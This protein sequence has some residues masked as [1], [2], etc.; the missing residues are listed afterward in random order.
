M[1][2]KTETFESNQSETLKTENFQVIKKKHSY[3]DVIN[4]YRSQQGNP[5]EVYKTIEAFITGEENFLILGD[6]NL[7]FNE[8]NSNILI[9]SL[10][11]S[12]FHQLIKTPTQ[13][14]GRIIDHAYFRGN[15]QK[16]SIESITYSPYYS[17]HDALLIVVKDNNMDTD[18][19]NFLEQLKRKEKEKQR[20]ENKKKRKLMEER[21]QMPN[22]KKLAEEMKE[23]DNKLTVQDWKYQN[24]K[25]M[26]FEL[27][28]DGLIECHNC[29][30]VIDHIWRH[31]AGV[32]S[33]TCR[34]DFIPFRDQWRIFMEKQK[35]SENQEDM[36]K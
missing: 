10:L 16:I 26:T 15:N 5:Q 30:D 32:T 21:S 14:C 25:F 23:E 18:N 27:L 33:R 7:C 19:P 28:S 1:Y 20:Q 12:N 4:L 31:I 24:G 11:K 17:D 22:K 9:Q 36:E 6:F 34:M 29:K 8:D 35:K 2:F 13:R 3:L